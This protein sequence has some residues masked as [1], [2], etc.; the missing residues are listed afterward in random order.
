MHLCMQPELVHL[1][2]T[3]SLLPGH[4]PMMASASLR[5]LYSLLYHGHIKH[6]QVLSFLPFSYYSCTCSLLRV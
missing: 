1:Y 5:L 3:S 4:L 2:Q 6:F